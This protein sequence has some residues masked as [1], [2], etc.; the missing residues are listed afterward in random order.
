VLDI[1]TSLASNGAIRT[2]ALEGRPMPEGW[3][4]NRKDGS[5]ITDPTRINEGTYLPMGGY[6]GSGLSIIIG[7]LAGPL[8][9]AAFGRDIRDFAAPPGRPAAIS[10]SGIRDRARR[11]TLHSAEVFKAEVDRH[12]NDL[13]SSQRLPGIDEIRVPGQARRPPPGARARRRAAQHSADR[14]GRRRRGARSA[15]CRSAL[16]H[17]AR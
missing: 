13:A 10:M 9:G 6:R 2:H 3:V 14:P 1:A 12:I 4:Q 11:R 15:S 7:L 8:N 16:D 5:A 17:R